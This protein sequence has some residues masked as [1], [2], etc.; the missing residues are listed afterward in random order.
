M[1]WQIFFGLLNGVI[2][3]VLSG[4]HF[5]WAGGGMAGIE[6]TLPTD[7]DGKRVL[8]PTKIDSALVAV[9]LLIF[10]LLFFRKAGV[11]DFYLPHL[12][13][14]LGTGVITFIFLLRAMGDFRYV[15]FSKKIRS[16]RFAEL[17][18]KYFSPL[19]LLLGSNGILLE[20]LA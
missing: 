15:G 12:I 19:C 17:D 10:A 8:N 16:T 18:T 13:G 20:I 3:I 14:R 11:L 7:L 6:S 5:Y 4:I 2:L 9:F 1:A